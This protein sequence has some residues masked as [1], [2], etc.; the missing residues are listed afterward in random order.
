[1]PD[2]AAEK[3]KPKE[4]V[5]PLASAGLGDIEDLVASQGAGFEQSHREAAEQGQTTYIDPST[6][7]QVF[8]EVAHLKRGKCCGSGCRHC[9]YSH[10]NVNEQDKTSRIK[11]PAWIY[12]SSSDAQAVFSCSG[13]TDIKVLFFSGGKDSFLTIRA[14]ARQY[15]QSKTPFGLVLLTTFDADSRGIAHQEVSIDDVLQQAQHLRLPLLGV[16]LHRG[17]GEGYVNRIGRALKVVERSFPDSS[18]SLVFGDLH[19]DHIR[20]WRETAFASSGYALEFPV[21]K[22]PYDALMDDLD[23]SGVPCVVTGSTCDYV[24]VGTP[25]DR[26]FYSKVV[27]EA[28]KVESTEPETNG[29]GM[30]SKTLD[31]F[32]ETGEFHSLAQVWKV[33]AALIICK[34]RTTLRQ[35]PS[36]P[37]IKSTL[38]ALV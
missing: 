34:K 21:W 28:P 11:Q 6:G 10:V 29:Q 3:S 14:L 1:M 12:Q 33:S 17:S 30:K 9:P 19:L 36:G 4:E 25:F 24:A 15:S 13:K 20:Q 26:A 2:E 5:T 37:H 31:A 7:Y 32:G 23:K 22:V 35:I 16:P 8:T 27:S 38:S 18:I